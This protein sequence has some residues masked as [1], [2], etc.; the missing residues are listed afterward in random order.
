MNAMG[1]AAQRQA[2]EHSAKYLT[3]VLG[4]EQYAI[5]IMNVREIIGMQ[6]ITVLPQSPPHIK[7]VINLRGKVIAVVDLRTKLGMPENQ[8]TEHTCTLVVEVQAAG[9]VVQV[10]L[11]VDAVSDVA[12]FRED[13]IES[14][15]ELNPNSGDDISY[16]AGLAQSGQGTT[17]ILD[18]DLLLVMDGAAVMAA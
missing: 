8:Y 18:T 17:I 3:F 15:P 14:S 12:L 4:E 1:Q 5:S 6:P 11:V 16:V 7:G 10:G 13:Q 2:E 9:R